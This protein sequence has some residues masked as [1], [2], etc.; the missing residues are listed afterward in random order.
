LLGALLSQ[1]AYAGAP[2]S[3]DL[4]IEKT[5]DNQNPSVGD[6]VTYTISVSNDGPDTATD[7][8]VLDIVD[9]TELDSATIV[10]SLGVIFA[11]CDPVTEDC[12]IIFDTLASGSSSFVEISF[13]VLASGPIEN[14][15]LIFFAGQPDPDS[16]PGINFGEDDDATETIF[17]GIADLSIEKI[18]D[19]LIPAVGDIITYTITVTNNGPDT[20]TGVVW[21]DTFD[22]AVLAIA[23]ISFDPLPIFP[24][25]TCELGLT[26]CT[27]LAPDLAPGDTQILIISF[28]VLTDGPINN[29]AEIVASDLLDPD[30]TPG[31]GQIGEDDDTTLSIPTIKNGQPPTESIIGSGS[32]NAV[33]RPTLGILKNGAMAVNEGF[34]FTPGTNILQQYCMRVFDYFNHLPVQVVNQGDTYSITLTGYFP[35]GA[36][37]ANYASVAIAS[38]GGDHNSAEWLIELTKKGNSNAWEMA[39]TDNENDP[40][41][42]EV[43]VTAQ[44]VDGN[45]MTFTFNIQSL[46]PASIGT[47]DGNADPLEN[48]K[49]ILTEIRD[50]KGS[51][52]RNIF[53]EGIY[54]NDI[55]AYPKIETSYEPPIEIEPLCLNENPNKRYTCAFDKV[56][57]WTIKN[58]EKALFEIS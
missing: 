33:Q 49:I 43:T 11:V 38:P 35:A 13:T 21:T 19:N 34:C 31:N 4:T 29:N 40:Y 50:S 46:K 24:G 27:I 23:G 39:I 22:P 47:L 48:N 12:A 7:I 14:T 53:N 30:S 2:T 9:E 10:N 58:A 52:T 17:A 8:R 18:V 56:K 54:V 26:T 45:I 37:R 32:S 15:A 1:S 3:A 41:L 28:T 42:G 57:Q 25:T 55:Y 44:Q 51:S 36:T 6:T 16:T 5:A 20:A